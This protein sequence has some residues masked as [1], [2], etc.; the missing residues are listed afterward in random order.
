[1]AFAAVSVTLVPLPSTRGVPV[2][3][4]HSEPGSDSAIGTGASS[5]ARVRPAITRSLGPKRRAKG[6]RPMDV[7]L[8]EPPHATCDMTED[9]AAPQLSIVVPAYNEEHSIAACIR[10]LAEQEIDCS[11]EV[12]L[13]D[14]NSTASTVAAALAAAGR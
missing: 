10:S 11:Y 1:M 3:V 5:T 4:V 9:T 2:L 6:S 8:G 13:V 14:N 7:T 12:I